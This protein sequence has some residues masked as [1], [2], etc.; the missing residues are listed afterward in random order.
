MDENNNQS[1]KF[2]AEQALAQTKYFEESQRL[3]TELRAADPE[4]YDASQHWVNNPLITPINK[5]DMLE[6]YKQ[7]ILKD[8]RNRV[9][10]VIGDSTTEIRDSNDDI[11]VRSLRISVDRLRLEIEG[12]AI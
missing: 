9:L 1:R 10:K 11:V 8:E 5:I 2:A 12:K 7:S 6:S 3:E 4:R